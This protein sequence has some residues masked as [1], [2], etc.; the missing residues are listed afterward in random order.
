MRSRWLEFSLD[1][2][3][4]LWLRRGLN[5]PRIGSAVFSEAVAE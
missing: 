4:L 3:D 5:V 1:A 2:A